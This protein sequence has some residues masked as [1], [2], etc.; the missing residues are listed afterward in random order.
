MILFSDFNSLISILKKHNWADS[1]DRKTQ[2]EVIING[3]QLG[4][5]NTGEKKVEIKISQ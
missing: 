1:G 3:I 4:N 5:G 2:M